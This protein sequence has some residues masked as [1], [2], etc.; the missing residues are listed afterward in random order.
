M[1]WLR[2]KSLICKKNDEM[3]PPW[4][5]RQAFVLFIII[6]S[7]VIWYQHDPAEQPKEINLTG[8]TMGT[9]YHITYISDSGINFQN[10]LDS[11]LAVFNLSL[12]TYIPESEI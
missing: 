12:S 9:T 11:L 7:L 4:R 10:D 5:K 1:I 3:N 6:A 8:K 2:L